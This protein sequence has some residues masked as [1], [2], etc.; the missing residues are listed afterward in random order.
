MSTSPGA[1]A[2]E[3]P[4]NEGTSESTQR[5]RSGQR[6]G[7]Q[8]RYS[9]RGRGQD[10]APVSQPFTGKDKNLGAEVVFKQSG[11]HEVIDLFETPKKE[12]ARYIGATYQNGSDVERSLSDGTRLVITVPHMPTGTVNPD[13]T[14][15]PAD[16][17]V[18]GVWK[19]EAGYEEI[20]WPRTWRWH[21]P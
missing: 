3:R 16:A 13:G 7:N 5:Q 6:I 11:G 15:N 2:T 14:V 1:E 18:M 17:S 21:T 20:S 19:M 10:R 9:G 4:T 12:I 8:G